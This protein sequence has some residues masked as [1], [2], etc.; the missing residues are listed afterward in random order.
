MAA[1]SAETDTN[2]SCLILFGGKPVGKYDYA[3]DKTL[4]A[5]ASVPIEGATAPSQADAK[6]EIHRI[7]GTSP[8]F[9]S[10]DAVYE[11]VPDKPAATSPSLTLKRKFL[12]TVQVATLLNGFDEKVIPLTAGVQLET[13]ERIETVLTLDTRQKQPML[14]VESPRPCWARWHPQEAPAT[15]V[16]ADADTATPITVVQTNTPDA[17]ILC[18]DNLPAGRWEIRQS[19]RVDYAGEF[20]IP[21]ARAWVAQKPSLNAESESLRIKCVDHAAATKQQ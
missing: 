17:L 21:S 3:A 11:D 12:R 1:Y 14:I 7:G 10:L 9:V 4:N 20:S 19:M 8:L 13:G 16:S 15:L 18:I 5:P 2:A 6:L